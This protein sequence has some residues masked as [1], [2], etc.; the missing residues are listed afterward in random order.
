MKTCG[1]REEIRTISTEGDAAMDSF[2]RR[3]VEDGALAR[4][5]R[6]TRTLVRP[7]EERKSETLD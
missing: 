3:T 7:E 6:R 4:W 5:S 2:R 1:R